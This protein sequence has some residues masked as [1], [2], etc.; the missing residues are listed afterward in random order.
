[1]S[2]NVL[3]SSPVA[4]HGLQ[5]H[6]VPH[7]NKCQFH[8]LLHQ[9]RKVHPERARLHNVD[10]LRSAIVDT[11]SN[12]D[13]QKR[14]WVGEADSDSVPIGPLHTTLAATAS[15]SQLRLADWFD[16]MRLPNTFAT[17]HAWRCLCTGQ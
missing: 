14:L 15:R 1:M 7:D 10:T 3:V 17:D 5:L 11:L 12:V 6:D 13:I 16:K 8:A 4:I 2:C 9:W